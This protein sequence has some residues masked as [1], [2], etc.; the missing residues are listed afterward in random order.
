MQSVTNMSTSETLSKDEVDTLLDKE[1]NE[2]NSTNGQQ[3]IDHYDLCQ[4]NNK[5]I[6]GIAKFENINE[7]FCREAST[8]T[9]NLFAKKTEIDANTPEMNSFDEFMK[10]LHHPLVIYYTNIKPINGMMLIVLEN[11]MISNLIEILF[12]GRARDEVDDTRQFSNLEI[13]IGKLFVDIITRS[14]TPAW[15]VIKND[16]K[17]EYLKGIVNPNLVNVIGL[18]ENV[19]TTKFNLT[20]NEIS[21]EFTLCYP[22]STISP[23]K[24][25]FSTEKES[26][27]DPE[28]KKWKNIMRSNLYS[29]PLTINATNIEVPINISELLQL[30]AGD[31]IPIEN[32]NFTTLKVGDKDMFA[33]QCMNNA[34][35]RS[36]TIDHGYID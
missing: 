19:I 3:N 17:F 34:G 6:E 33:G 4:Q 26:T 27:D 35:K 5:T 28:S 1:G 18:D 21:S 16:L 31:I 24:H 23:M 7:I 36:V 12:G 25:L 14:L 30:S 20:V 22:H 10:S 11:K 29:V 15:E 32:P 2:Q 8:T 13:A 9:T